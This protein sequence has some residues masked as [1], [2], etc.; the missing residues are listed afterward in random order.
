MI[1]KIVLFPFYLL[2]YTAVS[3]RNLLYDRKI[4]RSVSFD[5][6]VI[7]VGN[8]SVGGNGKTPMVE[9]LMSEF[10][11]KWKI[12]VLSRGYGRK[13][14]GFREVLP[15]DLAIDSG[16]EPLQIKRAF[17][18][19]IKVFVGEDRVEAITKIL[20]QYP[21]IQCIV[22][23]DAYQ[24]RAVK[25]GLNLLLTDFSKPF[26]RDYV[27]PLGRLREPRKGAKRADMIFVT[28]CPNNLTNELKNSYKNELK[29]Y[30]DKAFFTGLKY[31]QPKKIYHKAST[32]SKPS[33]FLVTAIANPAPLEQFARENYSVSGVLH[34]RDH[35]NFTKSDLNQIEAKIANF[36]PASI[37][38]LTTTKDA[39]RFMDLVNAGWKPSFD[40][41]VIQVVPDWNENEKLSFN[42]I[43][44][45]YVRTS[46]GDR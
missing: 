30:S 18:E 26:F 8:L 29:L 23:D 39:V 21:E 9:Y 7:N 28:K 41:S 2:Y 44:D 36:A 3:L 10:S 31:A 25:A 22:L 1:L 19:K 5:V 24:H 14:K 37:E 40:I 4:I 46:L 45:N 17:G 11:E 42:K 35:H 20:F 6:P 33:Y 34:F 12:A 32:G 43:I 13:S 15:E 16:D 38:M 27:L